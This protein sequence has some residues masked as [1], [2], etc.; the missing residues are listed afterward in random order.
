M[1]RVIRVLGASSMG[2]LRAAELYQ[3]GMHGVG[4]IFKNYR[5][6]IFEDD[7]EVAVLHGPAELGFLPLSLPMV[8]VRAT[9][10]SALEAS[11]FG[12]K[13]ADEL[14]ALAKS[15]YYQQRQWQAILIAAKRQ[16]VAPKVLS[17]FERWLVGGE[18]DLKHQD[19]EALLVELRA[20]LAQD[21]IT[22]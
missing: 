17:N 15:I 8:N 11:V 19:A 1:S 4:E 16:G 18:R 14:V 22:R 3:F 6:G 7:D 20:F 9:I 5:D 21:S 12:K 10:E 13:V 2:E